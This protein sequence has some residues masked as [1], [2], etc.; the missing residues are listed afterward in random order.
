[1]NHEISKNYFETN[2]KF[3]ISPIYSCDF[4][5]WLIGLLNNPGTCLF[6]SKFF[7]FFLLNW[8]FPGDSEGEESAC[9]GGDPGLIPR[10]ERFPGEENGYPLQYSCLENPMDRGAWWATQSVGS[11]R[12]GQLSD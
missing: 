11:Q 4:P 12:V 5:L 10:L 2:K 8:G 1:M 7:L 9:N 6:C 3:N